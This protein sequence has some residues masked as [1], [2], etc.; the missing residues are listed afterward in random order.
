MVCLTLNNRVSSQRRRKC[1][2]QS[3]SNQHQD[4]TIEQ[5]VN[6]LTSSL[7]GAEQSLTENAFQISGMQPIV[8]RSK[9]DTRRRDKKREERRRARNSERHNS[10]REQRRKAKRHLS[11]HVPECKPQKTLTDLGQGHYPRL[12]QTAVC[13]TES[14]GSNP[15]LSCVQSATYSISVLTANTS[16]ECGDSRLPPELREDW[17]LRDVSIPTGCSCVTWR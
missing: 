17:T 4:L 12:L 11:L 15:M 13:G 16:Q 6:Q 5:F 8:T 10:T 7:Q 3:G 1:H 2:S 14:C 9:K